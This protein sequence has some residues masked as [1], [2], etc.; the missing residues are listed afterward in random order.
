MNMYAEYALSKIVHFIG[1]RS[2]SPV[3]S[4]LMLHRVESRNDN[5]L[6]VFEDLNVSPDYLEEFFILCR[7]KGYVFISLD[8]MVNALLNGKKIQ[9]SF[10]LSIDDGYKSAFTNAYPI[11]RKYNIPFIFY[12]SSAFPDKRA[13]LWWD[14]IHDLVIKNNEIILDGSR[15]MDCTTLKN[16]QKTYILLSKMILKMGSKVSDG[17]QKLFSYYK[18]DLLS[19][20]TGKLIDWNDI[21][22]L[23]KDGLCTIGAHSENH[24][25]L[26]YEKRDAVFN[27][28]LLCKKRIEGE[29]GKQVNHLAYPYGSAYS[30][31]FREN[32]LAKRAGFFT[33]ATTF[34]SLVYR[35]HK[36]MLHSLP[37]IQLTQISDKAAYLY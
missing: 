4:I 27:E 37:R 22:I 12:I 8:E 30:V 34:S 7:D 31:G 3:S 29:I 11:L 26:R 15:E 2:G 9:K 6:P 20:N 5:H 25:G 19:L 33:A 1:S 36:D 17:I 23:S 14:M 32:S 18:R 16:K 35:H 21:K 10:V 28:F 24:Y 13:L